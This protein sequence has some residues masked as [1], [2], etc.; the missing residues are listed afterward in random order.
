MGDTSDP[1]CRP[2]HNTEVALLNH[3]GIPDFRHLSKDTFFRFL[4][5]LPDTDPEVAI[6]V[7]GQVPE[8]ATF[9]RAALADAT[10][11]F[12]A[13]LASHAASREMVHAVHMK[14]LEILKAELEK[15]L[16][17]EQWVRV[18]DDLREVNANELDVDAQGSRWL[19]DSLKAKLAVSAAAAFGLAAVVLTVSK[20]GSKAGTG[21][22]RL[23]K[24]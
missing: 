24:S 6:R 18:L 1:V 12:N 11:T 19:S 9:A 5:S 16:T 21:L 22:G 17:P 15:D 7:L 23:L 10:E 2:T 8:L 4:E 14:R 13:S 20:S 3:L